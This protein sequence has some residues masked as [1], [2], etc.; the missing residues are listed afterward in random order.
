M[1][2]K[3]NFE[4]FACIN[5]TISCTAKG[6][7]VVA[8]VLHD[9]MTSISDFDCYDAKEIARWKKD[10]WHFS[11]IVL[12]VSKN[13]IP[14]E[15]KNASLWGIERNIGDN[16]NYLMDTANELL[17]EAIA[18]GKAVLITTLEK[19]NKESNDA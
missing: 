5:D 13:G 1:S 19:L 16:N 8:T 15:I 4:D 6:F 7:D 10:E 11:G 17:E 2:F 3:D 18:E 12:S 9:E 14:L